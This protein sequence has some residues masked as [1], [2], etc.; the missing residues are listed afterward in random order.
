MPAADQPAT[1]LVVEDNP[2]NL[3][4][5]QAA[6]R[7]SFRVLAASSAEEALQVMLANRPDLSSWIWDCPV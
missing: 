4:L 7:R 1:V 3:K 5:V 6:L 2:T